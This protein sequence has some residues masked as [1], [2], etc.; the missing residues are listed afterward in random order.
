MLI[1][2]RLFW[3]ARMKRWDEIEDGSCT[4]GH[5]PNYS[6]QMERHGL[7]Q[8][9]SSTI[10][11]W[12]VV[13]SKFVWIRLSLRFAWI[14]RI[15]RKFVHSPRNR[16]S[17]FDELQ[18]PLKNPKFNFRTK[19]FICLASIGVKWTLIETPIR[20]EPYSKRTQAYSNK[21]EGNSFELWRILRVQLF[22][23]LEIVRQNSFEFKLNRVGS[24]R[25]RLANNY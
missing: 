24:L 15:L 6:L 9:L 17:Y 20:T 19:S 18:R 21:Y 8:R 16:K 7:N 10:S 5:V 23:K 22:C 25:V 12:I 13:C 2:L 3:V 4:Y 11:A 1:K 14:S